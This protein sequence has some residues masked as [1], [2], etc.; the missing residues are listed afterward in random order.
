MSIAA[1]PSSS[2]DARQLQPEDFLFLSPE[3]HQHACASLYARG[4]Y[5]DFSPVL[6][7]ASQSPGELTQQLMT[8]FHAARREGITRP[9]LVGAIPFD[10]RQ[11]ARLFIPQHTQWFAR[12]TLSDDAPAATPLKVNTVRE[13]PEKDRFCQMVSAGVAATRSGELDKIVL[14]RLLDIDTAQ[15]LNSMRLLLQLNLQNPWSYNFHVPLGK[16][17]ALIGA[18][19]ELLLHQ[20]GEQILTQP[21]AGSAHRSADPQEDNQ[22]RRTLM[23]SA[24][25]RHEHRLVI[26]DIRRVLAPY[27]TTLEIPDTPTLLSTPVLWHLASRIQGTLNDPQLNALTLACLLHPTPALCGVPYDAARTRIA[28]LEPFNR[29][30]FGGIVGWCDEHG[31]GQWVVTIRC[32]EVQGQRVRLFA[33]AGI[34]P[35]SQPLSEWHETGV[36]LSTMLRAFGLSQSQECAA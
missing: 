24:K 13:I 10:K 9:V 27:C 15:P 4:C 29:G 16:G 5:A 7:H 2:L 21:L 36:K 34:V 11:P 28:E 6:E 3:H 8:H 17:A 35:D 18:S 1:T 25:D 19:P 26:D 30:L 22:L 23:A 31:Q 14:S 33:G 32:G 12:H 20:Q